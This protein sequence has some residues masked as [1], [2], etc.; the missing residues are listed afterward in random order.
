MDPDRGPVRLVPVGSWLYLVSHGTDHDNL[1]RTNGQLTVRINDI[2]D[3]PVLDAHNCYPYKGQWSDRI[4]RALKTGFPVGI[5]QDLALNGDRVVVSH[6]AKTTGSEP[7]L[8]DHFFERVRPIVEKALKENDRA[9]WP[10]IVLHFDFKENGTPL[11]RAVWSLLGEYDG[12][13][14]TAVKTANPR[15][16]AP[17][18]PKPL[19]ARLNGPTHRP[20]S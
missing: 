12:W 20:P 13:Y 15:E 18:D 7:T 5:E 1:W 10:L 19:L 4:E 3:R 14:T 8:R 2:G 17:F 16:L 9:K 11:L 6:D